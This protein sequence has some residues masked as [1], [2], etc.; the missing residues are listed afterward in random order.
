VHHDADR[1]ARPGRRSQRARAGLAHRGRVGA[2]VVAIGADVDRLGEPVL[3]AHVVDAV[4]RDTPRVL[5]QIARAAIDGHHRA[6]GVAPAHLPR[7][8]HRRRGR[9]RRRCR[10]RVR[11]RRARAPAG[12]TRDGARERTEQDRGQPHGVSNARAR[13]AIRRD[14]RDECGIV[15]AAGIEDAKSAPTGR[16]DALAAE[17]RREAV[18]AR[19]R[20][21]T[22][23][24]ASLATAGAE[25][26]AAMAG[27]VAQ[28]AAAIEATA[29]K[30]PWRDLVKLAPGFAEEAARAVLGLAEQS[31]RGSSEAS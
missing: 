25:A 20:G 15:E 4:A 17:N 30:A 2:G 28:V 6:V 8:D 12:A 9:R 23:A 5:A 21:R 13:R 22:R 18:N 1:A 11:R 14:R 24:V 3:R 26:E 19:G 16:V 27:L 10:C 7:I 31:A 29:G